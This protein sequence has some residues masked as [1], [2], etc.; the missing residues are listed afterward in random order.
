[1][2]AEQGPV[3]YLTLTLRLSEEAA[4]TPLIDVLRAVRSAAIALAASRGA[5]PDPAEVLVAA[6][7]RLGLTG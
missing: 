3:A 1:M 5:D 4:D 6:R 7:R 2:E